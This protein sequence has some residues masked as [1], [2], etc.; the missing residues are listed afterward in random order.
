MNVL[1]G[2]FRNQTHRIVN[3]GLP[4]KFTLPSFGAGFTGLIINSVNSS[5]STV[6]LIGKIAAFIGLFTGTAMSSVAHFG[7]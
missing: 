2:F 4:G 5:N 6:N 1:P 3:T 7:E